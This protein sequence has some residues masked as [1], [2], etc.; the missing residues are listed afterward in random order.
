[1]TDAVPPEGDAAPVVLHVL[2]VGGGIVALSPL[3]GAGG[4]YKGDLEH[5]ASWRP[6]MVIALSTELEQMQ[7]GAQELGQAVQDKGSRWVHLPVPEGGFPDGEAAEL[8]AQVSAQALRA[9]SGGGRV[10]LHSRHGGGRAGMAAL[11]LMVE[12]GEAKDDAQERLAGVV[13]GA[14]GTA[15][16]VAWA[17]D[18]EL[19]PV[20]FL[21]SSS[22]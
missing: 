4:D 20:P 3:P 8:W 16:Q 6:A 18:V 22:S 10:M 1:M 5:L 13:P 2:P 17:F 7:T 12:A 11:R 21:R 15:V 14:I 19:A 9:L